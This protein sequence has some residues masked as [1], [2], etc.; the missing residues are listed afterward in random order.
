[1]GQ[2]KGD[3]SQTHNPESFGMSLENPVHY[4]DAVLSK[5]GMK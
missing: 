5:G 2:P 1:M 4:F 3:G